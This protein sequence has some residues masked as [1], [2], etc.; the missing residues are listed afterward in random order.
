MS[1]NKY[2]EYKLVHHTDRAQFEASINRLIELGFMIHGTPEFIYHPDS[3]SGVMYI[4]AMIKPA[5]RPQNKIKRVL[6]RIN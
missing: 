1:E 2:P 5:R 3:D 4:Q 6:P